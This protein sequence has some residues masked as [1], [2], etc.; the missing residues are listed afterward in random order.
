MAVYTAPDVYIESI[1]SGNQSVATIS[2]SVGA[3]VGL[4]KN[5]RRDIAQKVN[6]WKQY[7]Q[8]YANGLETPYMEDSFLAYSVYGFFI[9]GGKELYIASAEA[10]DDNNAVSAK[11][12]GTAFSAVAS[13]DGDWGNDL[14]I[15]VTK[16]ADWSE[17]TPNAENPSQMDGVNLVYDFKISIKGGAT[18][19]VEAVTV[20]NL[21][22]RILNDPIA[23][24]WFESVTNEVNG[25]TNEKVALV[26]E[27]VT[28]SGGVDGTTSVKSS[29]YLEALTMFDP[30]VDEITMISIPGISN[31]E[32]HN[33][34]ISYA[35]KHHIFPVLSFPQST[36]VEEAKELRKNIK[37]AEY[38][39]VA[40]P[41]GI[42]SDPLTNRDKVIPPEGYYMGV[43]ARIIE[44]R[45]AWKAPAGTEA[46][47]VGF[48][49]MEI[50]ISRDDCGIL[51]PCGIVCLMTRKNYGLCVW[52]ARGIQD[53][54]PK[55]KYVSDHFL[56]IKIR[57]ELYAN[58]LYAVFE[59]NP[60]VRASLRTICK[61]YMLKLAEQGAFVSKEEGT[62]WFIV[63]D[64]SNNSQEDI[65]EGM[66]Y[67]DAGYA[68]VKPAE[69]VVIRLAH[70]MD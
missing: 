11:G 44:S 20:D 22:D 62:G 32:V 40:Y 7:V 12:K 42:I 37:D 4:T 68:P 29:D 9:N 30:F 35:K 56:N 26:E 36:T 39:A 21:E 27:T 49:E 10:S 34:V 67:I 59:P 1:R 52:G 66:L 24:E 46:G 43:C 16:N 14:S 69:F 5:G 6:S 65:D 51:N 64:D 19:T 58:T 63:C 18:T 38:G 61:N 33:G 54:D 2:N 45:G 28:L 48:N 47:I 60:E 57:K 8:L 15:I 50:D 3:M 53:E 13:S 70:S 25:G 41:W 55:M 31:T 23:G 17:G